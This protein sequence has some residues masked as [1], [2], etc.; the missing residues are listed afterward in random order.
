MVPNPLLIVDRHI[1][2]LPA[3]GARAR[4]LP[5]AEAARAVAV[6]SR[7]RL[8]GRLAVAHPLLLGGAG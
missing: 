5:V 3:N 6:A 4:P 8:L 1:A 7:V 2:P